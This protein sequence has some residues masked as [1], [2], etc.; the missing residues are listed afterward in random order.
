[1]PLSS[2]PKLALTNVQ[3]CRTAST[4][5][6]VPSSNPNSFWFAG[7]AAGSFVAVLAT[8]VGGSGVGCGGGVSAFAGRVI[9]IV[10]T[11]V[12]VTPAFFSAESDGT[13][14]ALPGRLGA[15]GALAASDMT[16]TIK[17]QAAA[18][19]AARQ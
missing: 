3:R 2:G 19:A 9:A 11:G 12:A 1:M 6:P 4:L 7:C 18:T 15:E 13:G 5:A 10:V 17:K 16:G 8:R 14:G